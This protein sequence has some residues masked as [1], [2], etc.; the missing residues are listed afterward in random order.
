MG[1]CRERPQWQTR[2]TQRKPS[3]C[4]ERSRRSTSRPPVLR[5]VPRARSDPV[6]RQP[7]RRHA[8]PRLLEQP[9]HARGPRRPD[10]HRDG[11]HSRRGPRHLHR[12]GSGRTHVRHLRSR[13]AR[14]RFVPSGTSLPQSDVSHLLDNE[15]LAP[16][17]P[18]ICVSSLLTQPSRAPAPSRTP[19]GPPTPCGDP[20]SRVCSG[21][22]G[23]AAA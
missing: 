6:A 5:A 11:E 7:C 21:S 2:A 3:R 14:P 22:S 12:S 16:A 20:G 15:T 4:S 17:A 9:D 18:P 10:R 23:V 19:A 1:D 13:D 8:A